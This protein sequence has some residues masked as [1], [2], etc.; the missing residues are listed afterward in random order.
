MQRYGRPVAGKDI[1]GRME[2]AWAEAVQR[3]M[4]DA[5]ILPAELLEAINAHDPAMLDGV[6]VWLVPTSKPAPNKWWRS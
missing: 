3:P 2:A 1:V 5:V 6:D 4:R